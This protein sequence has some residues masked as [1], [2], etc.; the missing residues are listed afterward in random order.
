M[1]YT[2]NGFPAQQLPMSR[3][4]KAWRK[5][6]VDF[7]DNRS[8]LHSSPIRESVYNMQVNY[9]LINGIIHEEDIKDFINPFN[10]KASYIP[11]RI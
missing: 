11:S 5:R 7:A 10:Q 2:G 8:Y 6:C 9:D 4:N 1:T 3:K